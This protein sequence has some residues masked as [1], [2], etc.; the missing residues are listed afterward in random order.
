MLIDYNKQQPTAYPN[1][2]GGEGTM[3]ACIFFDGHNRILNAR[4]EPGASIGLHCHETSSEIMFFRSGT[5]VA[6]IDGV[7]ETVGAGLCHYCP[8][9]SSHTLIN[10]GTEDLCFY[11]VVP[12]Q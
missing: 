4:L 1:F 2:K 6:I 12:E 10:T 9:G 5:G 11:A 3:N 7:E 8:K